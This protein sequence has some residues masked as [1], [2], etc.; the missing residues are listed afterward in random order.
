MRLPRSRK[1]K[2]AEVDAEEAKRALARSREL[3]KLAK[4]VVAKERRLKERNN[5]GPKIAA[6]FREAPR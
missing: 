2:S 1:K 5:F 4:Q 6:A 3:E